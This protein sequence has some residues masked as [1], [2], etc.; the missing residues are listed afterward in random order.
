MKCLA[1]EARLGDVV[2]LAGL[3]SA[4]CGGL[5]GLVF[6]MASLADA[7]L[8][9]VGVSVL[10]MPL[11]GTGVGLLVGWIPSVLIGGLLLRFFGV[12]PVQCMAAGYLTGS[13]LL[14]ALSEFRWPTF[15]YTVIITTISVL[16]SASIAG[17]LAWR[18]VCKN[19]D[20]RG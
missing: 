7:G 2:A 1:E 12:G 16:G 10:V 11:V 19:T 15:D 5:L 14:L 4:F 18:N 6:A 13:L 9:E 20:A 8:V 3:G 17:Y